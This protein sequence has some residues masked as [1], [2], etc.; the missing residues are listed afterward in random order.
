ME[1]IIILYDKNA[2]FHYSTNVR[3]RMGFEVFCLLFKKMSSK[4]KKSNPTEYKYTDRS[5]VF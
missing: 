2:F 4:W 1:I 5:A 3:F